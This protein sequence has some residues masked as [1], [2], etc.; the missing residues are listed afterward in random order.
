[1]AILAWHD[2]GTAPNELLVTYFIDVDFAS[3]PLHHRSLIFLSSTSNVFAYECCV[4]EKLQN[5]F[6]FLDFL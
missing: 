6:A 4:C 2:H 3:S 1:M 5:S